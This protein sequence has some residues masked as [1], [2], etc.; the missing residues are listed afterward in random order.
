MLQQCT[1]Y[2]FN[3]VVRHVCGGPF[4]PDHSSGLLSGT[5]L[6]DT[7]HISCCTPTDPRQVVH[8]L[9][10]REKKNPKTQ[11]TIRAPY[12]VPADSYGEESKTGRHVL[13]N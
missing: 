8:A 10:V 9:R 1:Q 5:M 13:I 6:F 7:A 11:I 4:S 3:E 12:S 2:C